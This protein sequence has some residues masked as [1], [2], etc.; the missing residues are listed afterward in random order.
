MVKIK[1]I[2]TM[3]FDHCLFFDLGH[4]AKRYP[5]STILTG[6]NCKG[7]EVMRLRMNKIL[8]V[9]TRGVSPS[10]SVTIG[11]FA[12]SLPKAAAQKNPNTVNKKAQVKTT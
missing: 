2:L 5:S 3:F 1:S 12:T 9:Q 11:V 8:M 4:P 7:I 10:A 6:V